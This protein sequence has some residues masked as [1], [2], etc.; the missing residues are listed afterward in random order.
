MKSKARRGQAIVLF[1]LT[2][3]VMCLFAFMTIN[4]GV[5]FYRRIQMQNAADCASLSATRILARSLNT[6]ANTNNVIGIP[7]VYIPIILW[8]N[9]DM[10]INLKSSYEALRSIETAWVRAGSGQAAAVGVKVAKLN[11]ADVAI[12]TG[13]FSLKLKGRKIRVWWYKLVKIPFVGTVPVPWPPF[14]TTY[15]PAYYRRR[16]ETRTKKAQPTHNIRFTVY[17]NEYRAFGK[18]LFGGRI[19]EKKTYANARSKV[20][21]DVK[22]SYWLH[23]G[24]FPRS[25]RASWE[26]KAFIP[27]PLS[28]ANPA[29]FN[30]YLIPVGVSYF[31]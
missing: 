9:C 2:M 8:G 19:T 11:G 31:H 16:W 5:I 3:L 12:P 29:Q 4:T 30:A 7:E 26:E 15:N 10:N 14:K 22:K 23:Y 27:Q 21:Y 1:A 18:S 20:Y 13:S 25:S 17:K 6:V 28:A 24:G